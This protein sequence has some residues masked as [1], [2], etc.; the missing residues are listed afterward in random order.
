MRKIDRFKVLNPFTN[1]FKRADLLREEVAYMGK[2]VQIFH[3][4]SLGSEPFLISIGDYTKI[5]YGV[6]FITHD[7]GCYVLRSMYEDSKNA[8]V[9]GTIKIGNNCFIGND[10]II[11]PGVT[12]GNNCVI[13]AGSIVSRSI[14]DNSVAAGSPCRVLRTIDEYHEKLKPFLINT[15]GMSQTDKKE[16][17]LKL[18]KENPE[19]FVAK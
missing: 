15:I 16:Y 11:L 12:I 6:K 2:M 1:V 4:V 9:Y 5:T 19:K 10:T 7:G 8:S 13:A 14:P 17:L 18:R 3:K